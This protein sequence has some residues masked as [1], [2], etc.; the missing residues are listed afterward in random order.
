MDGVAVSLLPNN[1]TDHTRNAGL[2]IVSPLEKGTTYRAVI[3]P[4]RTLLVQAP[5]RSLI[6]WNLLLLRTEVV[7]SSSTRAGRIRHRLRK[8]E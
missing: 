1:L 5:T 6:T 3:D 7:P 8:I 2:P 4:V